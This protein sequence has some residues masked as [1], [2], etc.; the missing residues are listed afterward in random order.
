ML[1][2]L[3][4]NKKYINKRTKGVSKMQNGIGKMSWDG[5]LVHPMG[6]RLM[7]KPRKIGKTVC[8]DLGLSLGET[9]D[10]ISN[11]GTYIDRIKIAFGTSMIYSEDYLRAKLAAYH[12]ANITV[13]TGGTCGE[14]AWMQGK[15]DEWLLKA[16][17]I[18]FTAIEVSDGT[19][20]VSDKERCMMIEKVLNAGFECCTEVGKKMEDEQLEIKETIRQIK[21]DH[22]YGISTCTIESRGAAKGVGV[23][24]KNGKVKAGDIDAILNA[25]IEPTRLT[26]EAPTK[27]AHEF[28]IAYFGN[29]VNLG[30]VRVNEVIALEGLRCGVRGDTLVNIVRS[31]AK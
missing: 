12:S 22:A 17:D 19:I 2:Y 4:V 29:N 25:G 8:S 9:L 13:N 15:F 7:E 24:D 31:P 16:K 30:N 27:T 14:I 5:I 26:W 6:G 20:Q 3:G 28:F 11:C 23:F 21:R 1:S 18:G 10:V